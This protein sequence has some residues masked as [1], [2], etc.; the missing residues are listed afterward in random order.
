MKNTKNWK[1]E[2]KNAGT[3]SFFEHRKWRKIFNF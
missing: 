3:L 2:H 1:K